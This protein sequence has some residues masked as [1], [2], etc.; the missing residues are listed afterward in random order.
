MGIMFLAPL[1]IETDHAVVSWYI[2]SII[3]L[4]AAMLQV[5]RIWKRHGGSAYDATPGEDG[6]I[7]HRPDETFEDNPDIVKPYTV[8]LKARLF[9]LL[10]GLLLLGGAYW[11]YRHESAFIA[12]AATAQGEIIALQSRR[13]TEGNLLYTPKVRFTPEGRRAYDFTSQVS[14]SHPGYGVGDRVTVLYDPNAP[15]HAQIDRGFWNH[16]LPMGMGGTG[17]LV[18]IVTLIGLLRRKRA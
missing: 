8:P 16:V 13:D 2:P 11:L 9:S 15:D 1:I 4:S 18:L 10:L 7:G 5:G 14:S 3:L 6:V 17:A 12:S